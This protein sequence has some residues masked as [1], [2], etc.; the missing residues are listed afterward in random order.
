MVGG[1]RPP[2]GD[3]AEKFCV[4]AGDTF[5]FVTLETEVGPGTSDKILAS[6]KAP[7]LT[8]EG[9]RAV[10]GTSPLSGVGGGSG[11]NITGENRFTAL[12]PG[13]D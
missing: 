12:S 4:H 13:R 2:G 3:G 7:R 6:Q 8:V 9:G 10:I 11:G 5:S 1:R